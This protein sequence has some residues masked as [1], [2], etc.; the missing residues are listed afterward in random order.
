MIFSV[1]ENKMRYF[2]SYFH[3]DDEGWGFGNAFVTTDGPMVTVAHLREITESLSER[4]N[5]II[6]FIE[7]P[8]LLAEEDSHPE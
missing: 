2:V 3:K 8:D 5:I 7:V 1:K 6:S 4:E